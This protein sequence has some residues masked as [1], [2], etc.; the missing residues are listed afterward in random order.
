MAS[1]ILSII[2]L[3]FAAAS[4]GFTIYSYLDTKEREKKDNIVNYKSRY[5]QIVFD[6]YLLY[7][8]PERRQYIRFNEENKLDDFQGLID[9]LSEL[10]VSA[11]YFKYDNNDFYKELKEITQEIEDYLSECGNKSYDKEDQ[12]QV[13]GNINEKVSYLYSYINEKYLGL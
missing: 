9:C 3:I 10:R 11:L 7:E 12:Y 4:V 13:F 5:F 6:D 2:S 1:I 8:I